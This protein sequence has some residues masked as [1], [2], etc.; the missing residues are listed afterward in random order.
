MIHHPLNMARHVIR[1]GR[2]LALIFGFPTRC[3]SLDY[4]C[5]AAERKNAKVLHWSSSALDERGRP[6]AAIVLDVTDCSA[7]LEEVVEE[8]ERSGAMNSV[9]AYLSPVEGFI[10]DVA[11]HPLLAGNNRV[12]I[13]RD[14]G[15]RELL[16]GLRE[17]FGTNGTSF[18]YHV[19]FKTGSGFGR[20]H[21]DDAEKVGLKDPVQIYRNI[22]AAMFQW[23]GF[24]ILE[25]EELTADGGVIVVRD[26]FEC[27]LGKNS[28]TVYSQFVRGIIAGILAELFGYGFNVVEEECIAKGDQVC[29]FKLKRITLRIDT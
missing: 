1:P 18:L 24:G 29:R 5:S 28:A 14:S 3:A 22:S 15:Y 16:A 25:V 2:R 23:A 19:G 12:V 27:E 6:S 13:L 21:K 9:R 17:W 7:P 11:S 4:V 8:L 26:S 20:L 10:A